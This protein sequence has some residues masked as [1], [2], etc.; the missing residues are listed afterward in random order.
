MEP[1]LHSFSDL[2]SKDVYIHYRLDHYSDVSN[3]N[4]SIEFREFPGTQTCWYNDNHEFGN[5]E[6]SMVASIKLAYWYLENPHRIEMINA[7]LGTD[8]YWLY[9]AELNAMLNTLIKD[10]RMKVY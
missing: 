9:S 6:E 5:I 10:E 8:N 7:S 4:F 3:L 1:S 2:E